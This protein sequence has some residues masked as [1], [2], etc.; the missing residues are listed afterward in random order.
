MREPGALGDPR[1]DADRPVGAGRDQ[2][3]DAERPDEPLDRRL[4][5]RREDAAPVGETKPEGRRVPVDNGQPDP[6]SASRL[7]QPE[8]SR[9]CP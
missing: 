8:L 6:A 4:V 1:R 5:V 3:F 2:P 9:P 7:E